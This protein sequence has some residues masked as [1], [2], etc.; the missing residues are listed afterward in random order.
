MPA[1]LIAVRF[2]DGRYHGRPDWPPSPA[3]LFQALVAGAARG[4]AIAD[5]DMR[6]LSWLESLKDAPT[7]AA[8]PHRPGQGFSNYV[9]N[10]D[11]DAKGGDPARVNEI[12]APKL[13]RPI[14]FD[15]E[16]PLL[17]IWRFDNAARDTA[18]EV[19]AIA[20]R[21]YQLGRGVDMAWA[22]GEVLDDATADERLA[23]Y[24]GAVH[25]P[26][27]GAEGT[28]LPAPAEGSLKSLMARHAHMRFETRY[29]PRPTKK[30]PHRQVAVG[31]TFK[32]PPKPLFRQVAYDS[33]PTRLLFDLIGAQTP[34]PLRNIAAFATELRDAAVA[35]L[36]D[37][38]KSKAGEIER[39]LIGR[40]A[41]DADKPRRVR[42]VPLPSIGHPKASPAIRRVLVE[43]PP[44]C[45][46]RADDVA[47]AFSGL[48][49]IPARINEET[50]E[51]DEQLT[52][53]SAADRRMLRHYGIERTAPSRLWRTIT[54]AAL[55]AARRRIPPQKR[56]DEDLKSGPERAREERAA[57]ASVRAALRHAGMRARVDRIRVQR[58]PWA[59]KGARA[60]AFEPDDEE[61]KQ[62]FSKHRLWHVEIAFAE[63]EH[64]PLLIGDG[65][66][67]GLGLMHPVRRLAGVHAFQIVEGSAERVDPAVIT[68]ALR[69]AVMARVAESMNGDRPN[70]APLP[71]FFTGH[72]ENG[73]PARAG[74]HRHLAYLFDAPRKRLL[75]LAPH[76]LERRAPSKDERTWL[77]RLEDALSSF[78][79][80]R[81]GRAGALRLAPAA[82]DLDADPLFAPSATW[83]T[84][85][86]Y[87]V[88]RHP[89]R[90][91]AHAALTENIQS[92]C[93]RL[94]LPSPKV[95]VQEAQGFAG[96]GLVGR[97]Q[98]AFE[99][100]V[101][102][103]LLI[104]R[105]RHFGGGLFHPA[106]IAPR[107]EHPF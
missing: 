55:S 14:L 3:R 86:P 79:L 1:L 21:L 39:C 68:R 80:L 38:L 93:R 17:Y 61:L 11:L 96:R 24:E 77:Q 52:L 57:I 73:A 40:G 98:L 82:V 94:G 28:P 7:I 15:A 13:I 47:W 19:C 90:R 83:E 35:K 100:A 30:D 76:V 85:T 74:G 60:E 59:A 72:D 9:P 95:C 102:G 99:V 49:L 23:L 42:I 92:E 34:V 4:K 89:K 10:N 41:D 20:E 22:T 71:V 37:K 62:R 33:P 64:G 65:R 91:D 12:R 104:G 107:R 44:A 45:P 16:T 31:Q 69:R 48:E 32:Q 84:L 87:A 5:E 8:P 101:A 36:S 25:A 27:R 56:S 66:Y 50:G 70:A 75:I 54:P 53:T 29:E 88:T 26:S 63:P 97:A 46:L 106:P 103:P 67:L 51:I 105:D 2:H 81:A 6:A 78:T 58:E 43:I 18:R